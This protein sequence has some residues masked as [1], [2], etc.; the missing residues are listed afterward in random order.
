MHASVPINRQADKKQV[1]QLKSERVAARIKAMEDQ[2]QAE[3]EEQERLVCA[4]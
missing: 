4:K 1:L 3:C 2:Q